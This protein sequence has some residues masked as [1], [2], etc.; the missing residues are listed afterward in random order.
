MTKR[1]V[2]NIFSSQYPKYQKKKKID[3]KNF[4]VVILSVY[5]FSSSEIS[6]KKKNCLNETIR[7]WVMSR[8]F[9]KSKVIENVVSVNKN[10]YQV[11]E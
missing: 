3:H 6:I 1:I 8:Q 2:R 9:N 7:V 4:F 10:D 11:H 5:F